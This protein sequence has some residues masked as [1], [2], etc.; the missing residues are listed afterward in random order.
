MSEALRPCFGS[1]RTI[2][3]VH[4]DAELYVARPAVAVEPAELIVNSR[5]DRATTVEYGVYEPVEARMVENIEE[6]R[7]ELE[8]VA[9]GQREVLVH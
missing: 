3:E 5:T 4:L 2:S 7:T 1:G 6:L 8:T 9:L